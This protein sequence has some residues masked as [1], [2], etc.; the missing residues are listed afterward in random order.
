MNSFSAYLSR[1]RD[2][3]TVIEAALDRPPPGG[4]PTDMAPIAARKF[5]LGA[6]LKAEQA[7]ADWK[8]TET[9][10]TRETELRIGPFR[11]DYNYQ[12]ADLIIHGPPIYPLPA[13]L[14]QTSCDYTSCGMAALAVVMVGISEVLPGVAIAADQDGYPE[15]IELLTT[16][17]TRL[18]LSLDG[19]RPRV[20]VRDSGTP[21][22]PGPFDPA[23]VRLLVFDTT[24][25]TASSG[26]IASV[27]RAAARAGI[28]VALVRSHT[29]LDSLG[30]EYGRLG[31]VVLVAPPAA[32][33]L[34]ERLGTACKNAIRLLGAAAVPEHLPPFIGSDAWRGLTRA[35]VARIIRNNRTAARALAG[36]CYQH[37][38]FFTLDLGAGW[39]EEQAR[40]AASGLAARL[41]EAGLPARR[42]G[43]FGFDFTVMD[44]FPAPSL[45]HGGGDPWLLR[46]AM[47]DLPD[48]TTRA[49][50]QRI[51]GWRSPSATV[52]DKLRTAE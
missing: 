33:G 39:T 43:S 51:A 46:I 23:D 41:I 12:R 45:S 20:V 6:L 26:R 10:W 14:T 16:Y 37:G 1:K 29:K 47:A 42:A 7:Q 27:L 9:H 38:L 21:D 49:I 31:S 35:R 19:A 44:A 8:F 22:Y 24:C 50:I 15:S 48:R 52:R 34:A 40:N 18:G 17:G 2:E 32:H 3:I 4:V 11:L 30:I 28:A 5:Q 36:R 25:L 13:G